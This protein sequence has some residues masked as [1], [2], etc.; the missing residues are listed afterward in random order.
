MLFHKLAE[1]E[2]DIVPRT[3]TELYYIKKK[4]LLIFQTDEN[5]DFNSWLI[6]GLSRAG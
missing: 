6:T 2:L 1:T 5:T 4:I 3:Q